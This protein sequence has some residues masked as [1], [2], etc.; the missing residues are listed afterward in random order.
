MLVTSSLETP[1]I[2]SLRG[3][4]WKPPESSSC[5]VRCL[6][7]NKYLLTKILLEFIWGSGM[8]G[9]KC[10]ACEGVGSRVGGGGETRGGRGNYSSEWNIWE[11]NKK[12]KTKNQ[13]T[14]PGNNPNFQ[15]RNIHGKHISDRTHPKMLVAVNLG[16]CRWWALSF[17]GS[18][19]FN[20]FSITDVNDK[21]YNSSQQQQNQLR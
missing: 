6:T 16:H 19:V 8:S 18:S 2:Q 14:A 21:N 10:V 13:K 9:S 11:K 5:L 7:L 1:E 3:A 17:P 15:T 12:N 20:V 4:L